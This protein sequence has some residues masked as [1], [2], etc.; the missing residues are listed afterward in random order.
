M[1][2]TNF[3]ATKHDEPMKKQYLFR[4]LVTI[5]ILISTSSFAQIV[6]TSGDMPSQG[7]TARV[8]TAAYMETQI[9][10]PAITGFDYSW[11]YSGLQPTAQSVLSFVNPIQTNFLYYLT[12]GPT[13]ANLAMPVEGLEFVDLQVTD[14]Y[15]F[16]R[17]T[18]GEYVRAGYAAT[19]MGIPLPLKYDVPERIYK[20]PLSVNS[21]PD[22][23]I[24]TFE[25]Q[26]PLVA[27]FY[28]YKKRV[29][30]VDGSGILVTPYGSFNTLR[31]KSVIYERDSL[32]LDSLQ[33]GIPIIRNITEYRWL[34]PDFP[35]PLLTITQEGLSY[36]VQYID[37][38]RNIIPLIV[39]LGNDIT[40]CEGDE[41]TL[42][43]QVEGGNPPYT[44]IWSNLSTT[45]SITISPDETT[46]YTVMVCDTF[47]VCASASQI[48]NVIALEPFELGNDT[49]LCA[50]L[51]L[52]FL[53][54]NN[55]DQITWY[56]NN[57][58][59]ETG[60]GFSVDSAGIGLNSAIVKVIY[61][62]DGCEKSDELTVT[63][64]LCGGFPEFERGQLTI[65]PNPAAESIAIQA[66]WN[67]TKPIVSISTLNGPQV[68]MNSVNISGKRLMLDI[69]N[70][71]PGLY[72]ITVQDTNK[73]TTGKFIKL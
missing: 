48:V 15:E 23:S 26:Y 69:S 35:V 25:I 71:K 36:S 50:E 56:V 30:S 51:T 52:N 67:L 22:S 72:F 18:T 38:V 21:T 2:F 64:Q 49:T 41:V 4:S 24:S 55:Y 44:Y 62:K 58:E 11:D 27:Y 42:T 40:I 53:I 3:I 1:L 34:S 65:T 10:D 54:D 47:G 16:Y 8:S 60:I 14:A 9:V 59:V 46:T 32:Y 66:S 13:V 12:F 31:V 70:L 29:N 39:S 43:A 68:I 33:T 45:E 20:F 19:I 5:L 7:D 63:F 61:Q 73:M 37:S 17:N 57:E 6:I 28:Q